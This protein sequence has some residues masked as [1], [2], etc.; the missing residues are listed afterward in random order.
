MK[1]E[2]VFDPNPNSQ[3]VRHSRMLQAGIQ[4]ESGL[5]PRLKHSGVTF[6]SRISLPQLQFSKERQKDKKESKL[7]RGQKRKIKNLVRGNLFGD[8]L[9]LARVADGVGDQ[10]SINL[11]VRGLN[12]LVLI[13]NF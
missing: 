11:A 13:I 2:H 7:S 6:R 12:L 4:A 5:D 3:R 10:I 9:S 1:M 8:T